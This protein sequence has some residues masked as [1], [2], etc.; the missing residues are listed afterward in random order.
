[1]FFKTLIK[2]R[3]VRQT[4]SGGLLWWFCS[5]ERGSSRPVLGMGGCMTTGKGVGKI[6]K[7]KRVGSTFWLRG[8]D[9][10]PAESGRVI[11]GHLGEGGRGGS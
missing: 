8:P 9:R 6:T 4:L 1:L 11:R 5:K 3:T 7:R 2:I 10:M